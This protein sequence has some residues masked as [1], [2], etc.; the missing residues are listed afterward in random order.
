MDKIRQILPVLLFVSFPLAGL[1]FYWLAVSGYAARQT[2][3]ILWFALCLFVCS[4]LV[5]YYGDL[6]G[7]RLAI[8]P[9]LIQAW[10][11]PAVVIFG[12]MAIL[13]AFPGLLM[14]CLELISLKLAFQAKISPTGQ[15]RLKS[16][17]L[18][19][20]ANALIS[21]PIGFYWLVRFAREI[22]A[23]P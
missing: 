17:V 1:Y 10:K 9:I 23:L 12:E 5:I 21:I 19:L 7:L 2:T 16:F 6:T 22:V 11:L 13:L 4:T 14:S 8:A 18:L 20:L 15:R 3:K